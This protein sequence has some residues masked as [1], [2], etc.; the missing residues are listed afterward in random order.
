LSARESV[1][2]VSTDGRG[3]AMYGKV[4]L[5]VLAMTVSGLW[6]RAILPGA[7]PKRA[8]TIDHPTPG[9]KLE[10]AT[11]GGGCFWHVEDDFRKV[12]GVVSTAVGYEG[13]TMRHPTYA[14]VC[15]DQTGHVEVVQIQFDPSRIS[16]EGLLNV[17]FLMHDPTSVDRQGPDAGT[18]YRSVIFYHS[19]EQKRMAEEFKDGL[20]KS[21]RFNLPIVTRIAPASTFWKAEKY[22]Q[23]YY[24]KQGL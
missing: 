17:F 14:D 19:P 15:T 9:A 18:Q 20:D 3:N 22:H 4:I 5:G 21:G 8:S 13:G 16:Y 12:E 1:L 7:E 11:F 2:R 23:Q 10:T 24:E 6:M